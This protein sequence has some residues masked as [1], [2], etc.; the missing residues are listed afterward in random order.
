MSTERV[1]PTP[2]IHNF[3]DYGGYPTL[4]GGRVRTGKLYRSGHHAEASEA[5]LA[6]VAALELATVIDLRGDSE[7]ARHTCRRDPGFDGEVIFYEGETAG[8]APHL[9][10][11]EGA[12]DA[13]SARTA[14]TKLYAALPE[15]T[16]LNWTLKRYFAALAAGRGASLV[17]CAA[18]KDR[19]GIAVDFLHQTLGVHPDDA[20]ADYLLTNAMPNNDRRIADGMAMLGKKYGARDEETARVLMGVEPGFLQAARD[21][22]RDTHG[23]VEGYV[24]HALG[25]DD[26]MRDALRL[27]LVES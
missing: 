11:A 21:A 19:T 18:G 9:E 7:R 2:S 13:D 15:R 5:D 25:V 12:L 24:T 17:H 20:M 26:A 27:H 23:S 4:D 16:G 14:M 6:K 3:R 1:L 10:A 22:A 8:L